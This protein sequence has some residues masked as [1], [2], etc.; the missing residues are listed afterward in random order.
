MDEI[1]SSTNPVEGISGA[2]AVAKKISQDQGA[3]LLFTTHFVYLTKLAKKV[4]D[5]FI[6]YKMNVTRNENGDIEF[7]YKLESGISKQFVALEL[8]KKSGYD[9]DV[10]EEA[11]NMKEYLT[12]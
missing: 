1:F 5:R 9:A 12:S 7:P 3:M 2:Y 8:L 10:I 11:L 6:N 4:P